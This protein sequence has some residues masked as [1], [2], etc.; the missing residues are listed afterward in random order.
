MRY[1]RR[2]NHMAVSIDVIR[3]HTKPWPKDEPI[4]YYVDSWK[5]GRLSS[6]LEE[7]YR[8]FGIM[9]RES[10]IAVYYDSYGELHVD[11]CK[12]PLFEAHIRAYMQN[13]YEHI[14]KEEYSRIIESHPVGTLLK[15]YIKEL[16]PGFYQVRYLGKFCNLSDEQL[17]AISEKQVDIRIL[18]GKNTSDVDTG[19]PRLNDI[20]LDMIENG[21]IWP[22]SVADGVSPLIGVEP[23]EVLDSLQGWK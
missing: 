2:A 6:E 18:E 19:I 3:K 13:W 21:H 5:S 15:P 9:S 1:E 17:A 7:Y 16:K 22:R 23:D 11:R 10:D 4:R 20:L 14:C 12:N 8:E